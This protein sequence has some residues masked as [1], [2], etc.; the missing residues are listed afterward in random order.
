M[1]EILT[2]ENSLFKHKCVERKYEPDYTKSGFRTAEQRCFTNSTANVLR[3]QCRKTLYSLTGQKSGRGITFCWVRS[4]LSP[5]AVDCGSCSK[6][7][8]QEITKQADP[9]LISVLAAAAGFS[10]LRQHQQMCAFTQTDI[11]LKVL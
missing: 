9:A 8:I 11:D 7:E 3:R 1:G 5:A 2:S 6:R 10:L 4:G